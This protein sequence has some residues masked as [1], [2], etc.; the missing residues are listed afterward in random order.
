MSVVG[1][2]WH[3]MSCEGRQPFSSPS[4]RSAHPQSLRDW[5]DFRGIRSRMRSVGSSDARPHSSS[6]RTSLVRSTSLPGRWSRAA[7]FRWEG[8]PAPPLTLLLA[9]GHVA[10][11]G[12]VKGAS[13]R[14][15]TSS[16]FPG[17][18]PEYIASLGMRYVSGRQGCRQL[19]CCA[20]PGG[21]GHLQ[22]RGAPRVMVVADGIHDCIPKAR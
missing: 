21:A 15:S 4:A 22:R 5:R 9:C 10:Q 6:R 8:T 2:R 18:R 12:F 17:L 16:Q 7:W 20:I 1:Q 3:R 19:R 14:I 11:H 13:S